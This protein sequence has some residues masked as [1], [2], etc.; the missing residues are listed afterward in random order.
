MLVSVAGCSIHEL[1]ALSTDVWQVEESAS[2]DEIHLRTGCFC[3]VG[4][5]QKWLKISSE[6]L[7]SHWLVSDNVTIHEVCHR[8]PVK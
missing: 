8:E 7:H 2:A 4:A 5:C 6:R 3:N 1:F